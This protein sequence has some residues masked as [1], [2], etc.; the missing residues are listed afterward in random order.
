MILSIRC[1]ANGHSR[2]CPSHGH[3]ACEHLRVALRPL[4]PTALFLTNL[5]CS[6]IGPD[7]ISCF[8]QN[9]NEA[10]ENHSQNSP[11]RLIAQA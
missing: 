6:E 9:G 7:F 5:R 10:A 2:R 4:P 8:M 1:A 3:N 11:A